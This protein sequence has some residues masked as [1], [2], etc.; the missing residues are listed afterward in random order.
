M[1]PPLVLASSSPRRRELLA[2]LGVDFVVR[3]ADIDESQLADTPP[4]ARVELLARMKAEACTAGAAEV[5]LAADTLVVLDGR[6]L[7]KPSDLADAR[8]TLALLRGREHEVVTGVALRS[9]H[10]RVQAS[11]RTSVHMRAYSDHEVDDFVGTGAAQ[12]KA[13]AYAIQ[14]ASFHPV[15][16]IAGCYC[17]VV[18]LP[19]GTVRRLLAAM[20]RTDLPS[21]PHPPQCHGCP[22]WA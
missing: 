10:E 6:A 19:L 12:D 9:G 17:N 18:G 22:D 3:P 2:A 4:A 15:N 5:V 16:R 8:Q 20:L 7:G 14:D 1:T 21:V 11:V 13:G